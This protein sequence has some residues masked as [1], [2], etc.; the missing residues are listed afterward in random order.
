MPPRLQLDLT[1]AEQQELVRERAAALLKVHAGQSA[2][3]VARAGLLR[4]RRCETV[5]RWVRGYQA[6]GVASFA[7]RPGRGRKPAFSPPGT[8]R[9]RPAPA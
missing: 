9:G 6:A 4:P 7:I 1:E 8:D 2:R 3:A 5:V